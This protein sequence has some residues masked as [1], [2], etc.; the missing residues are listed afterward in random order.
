[1][2][3]ARGLDL[4][5]ASDATVMILTSE[6]GF[7]WSQVN[8]MFGR[9][10]RS[11]GIPR[12]FYFTS[13]FP[14]GADMVEQLKI[15]ETDFRESHKIVRLL[16]ENFEKVPE[17]NDRHAIAAAF[18]NNNWQGT[19][20]YFTNDHETAYNALMAGKVESDEDSESV[21]VNDL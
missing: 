20:R 3:Y 11:F 7:K 13:Q 17:G 1:V 10:S 16:F 5:L 18:S 9:G 4:K 19:V 8:Q 2:K 6:K 14:H 12:G 15:L 21:G